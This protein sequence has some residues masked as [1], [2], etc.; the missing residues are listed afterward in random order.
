MLNFFRIRGAL[1]SSVSLCGNVGIMLVYVT[2]NFFHVTPIITI[3]MTILYAIMFYFFPETPT[4]LMTQNKI[5][6]R[7]IYQ[8]GIS[9]M[10]NK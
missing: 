7:I 8:F 9:Y 10:S 4:F 5:S 6:V 2:G 1:S 3:A